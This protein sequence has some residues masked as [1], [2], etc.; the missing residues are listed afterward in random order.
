MDRNQWVWIKNLIPQ[1]HESIDV[2]ISCDDEPPKKIDRYDRIILLGSE[3]S[4]LDD[5]DWLKP[6][7]NLIQTAIERGIPLLGICFGHQII[8]HAV[9]GRDYVR[10]R[11]DPELGWSKIQQLK[12][13]RLFQDIPTHFFSYSFHFDEVVESPALEILARSDECD[14]QAYQLKG[15]DVWGIQFHPEIDIETGKRIL[16]EAAQMFGWGNV[17]KILAKACDS[18]IGSQLLLN[19]INEI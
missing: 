3:A 8:V 18:S 11:A 14:V 2:W 1:Y 10:R 16:R 7:L 12:K 4:A 13:N 9:L 6:E 17:E 19:F 5:H 15:K